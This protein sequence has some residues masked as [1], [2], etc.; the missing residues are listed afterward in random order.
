MYF[1]YT[2]AAKF[3]YTHI[4]KAADPNAHNIM[5]VNDEPRKPIATKT[6]K[7]VDWTDGWHKVRLERKTADGS[8]KVFFDDMTTPIMEATD[9]TFGWGWAGFGS[10]DDSGFIGRVRI[11]GP[12]AKEAACGVF[13]AKERTPP[14]AE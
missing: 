3:Y 9:K 7:G 1:G 6:T 13:S 2:D 4:A 10:F 12:E 5:I 8:I 14:H 11:W